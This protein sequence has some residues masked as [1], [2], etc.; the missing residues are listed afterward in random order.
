MDEEVVVA[1]TAVVRHF[2]NISD[3]AMI[4]KI[5]VERI[6]ASIIE[7]GECAE[8]AVVQTFA[9]TEKYEKYASNVEVKESVS[10]GGS[11]TS[12]KTAVVRASA[13]TASSE[14]SKKVPPLTFLL[15]IILLLIYLHL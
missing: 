2:A 6:S 3:D 9:N 5:V 15:R 1:R 10:T 12:V 14:V 11:A 7:S 13:N 4:V 8:I